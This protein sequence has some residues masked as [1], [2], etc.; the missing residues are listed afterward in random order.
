MLESLLTPFSFRTR[1]PS[2]PLAPIVDRWTIHAVVAP[3]T[4]SGSIAA[5]GIPSRQ[6]G[7]TR[8]ASK[9]SMR[10]RRG[11]ARSTPGGAGRFEPRPPGRPAVQQPGL[12]G[13]PPWLAD[14]L[15]RTHGLPMHHIGPS[16]RRLHM[17]LAPG[18]GLRRG[19]GDPRVIPEFHPDGPLAGGW[20]GGAIRPHSNTAFLITSARQASQAR[21]RGSKCNRPRSSPRPGPL[22]RPEAAIRRT[23]GGASINASRAVPLPAAEDST[24][25][26]NPGPSAS[27][28]DEPTASARQSGSRSLRDAISATF[29]AQWLQS[30]DRPHLHSWPLAFWLST[31]DAWPKEVV[32]C[33]RTR[34]LILIKNPGI[35]TTSG[36]PELWSDTS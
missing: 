10:M 25:W 29:A 24:W 3:V 26:A 13:G 20:T 33:I 31:R 8:P 12:S 23:P 9:P 1:R 6:V 32:L 18:R 14:R 19:P 7:P 22:H 36:F 5:W 17:L 4:C 2:S 15:S 21:A 35:N 27:H 11:S 34:H 28:P 16:G 30:S